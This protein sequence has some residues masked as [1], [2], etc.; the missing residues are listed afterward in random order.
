MDRVLFLRG[1]PLFAE[2][3]P[4]DLK[5]VAESATEAAFPDGETIAEQGEAGDEM[6]IVVSGDIRVVA[7]G[8]EIARRRPGDYVGEMAILS[9][10][11]RM[12]ALVAAGEVR[13]L[14]IDRRRFQRIVEDRPQV[15]LAVMRVLCD[16][17]RE[18]HA[19]PSH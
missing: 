6:H 16:R 14:S 9:E 4:G 3:D 5:H 13:T 7:G 18:S 2:L 17:L 19:E 15:S 10:A 8:H 12:A 1:V 11:P